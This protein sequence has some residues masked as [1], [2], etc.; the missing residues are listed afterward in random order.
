MLI[1]WMYV[2]EKGVKK[3]S[4]M[5]GSKKQRGMVGASVRVEPQEMESG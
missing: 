2:L 1:I 5:E 4:R 3:M